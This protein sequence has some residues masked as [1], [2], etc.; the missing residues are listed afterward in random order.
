MGKHWMTTHPVGTGPFTVANFVTD[1][2]MKLVKNPNYWAKD[3]KGG[4]LPYLDGV[5]FTFTADATTTLMMAKPG[6]VDMVLQ[7]FSG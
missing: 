1:A 4:K 7:T 2:S 3:A 6:N 5:D